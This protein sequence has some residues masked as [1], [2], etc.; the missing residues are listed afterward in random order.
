MTHQPALTLNLA[1]MPHPD[2]GCYWC[3]ADCYPGWQMTFEWLGPDQT[4]G[5][6]AMCGREYTFSSRYGEDELVEELAREH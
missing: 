5:R 3:C 2:H 1:P 6:C 4:R